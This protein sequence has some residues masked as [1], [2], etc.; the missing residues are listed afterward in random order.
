V[1]AD[2]VDLPRGEVPLTGTARVGII[3]VH[4]PDAP[5]LG[6]WIGIE[7]RSASDLSLTAFCATARGFPRPL[8]LAE[9]LAQEIV[10]VARRASEARL[11]G[12]EQP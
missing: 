9:A 1:S 10:S 3:A 6:L 12:E 7:A 5:G 8:R 4:R 2:R 11:W